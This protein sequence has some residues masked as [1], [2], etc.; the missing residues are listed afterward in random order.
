MSQQSS[1]LLRTSNP[2]S[3]SCIDTHQSPS[4]LA[5]YQIPARVGD[6]TGVEPLALLKAA[7]NGESNRD[8]YMALAAQDAARLDPLTELQQVSTASVVDRTNEQARLKQHG[9]Q[10]GQ[11][12]AAAATLNGAAAEYMNDAA[13]VVNHEATA[14]RDRKRRAN[15]AFGTEELPKFRRIKFKV[16]GAVSNNAAVK[17]QITLRG[18]HVYAGLKEL[19]LH[20]FINEVPDYIKAAPGMT[21]STITIKDGAV[22]SNDNEQP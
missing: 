21:T 16:H 7:E 10:A 2:V 17:R 8:R 20:G 9:R 5:V 14:Q 6:L 11:V 15:E 18:S 13:V 3:S 4:I 12:V 1:L 22:V 19:F